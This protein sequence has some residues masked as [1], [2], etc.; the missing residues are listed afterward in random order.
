MG[1]ARTTRYSDPSFITRN[2]RNP[3]NPR[4]NPRSKLGIAERID[5]LV[6]RSPSLHLRREMEGWAFYVSYAT[7]RLLKTVFEA[8]G[9]PIFFCG[10]D[11]RCQPLS[12][13]SIKLNT[14]RQ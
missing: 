1:I 4:F 10:E 14:T 7:P 5:N 8:P 12:T 9:T 3:F 11:R 6:L 13:S 2:L